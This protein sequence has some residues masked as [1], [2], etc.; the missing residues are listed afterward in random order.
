MA[1][2]ASTTPTATINTYFYHFK[3][4][5]A[6]PTAADFAKAEK[7]VD[8]KSYGDLGGEPNALDATTLSDKVQ[9]TVNGVQKLE[10]IKLT[11][12][13][14]KGDSTKLATLSALGEGEW[15][16][17]AMGASADGTPDG[18]DGIYYWQGGLSYYEN[19]GEVDKVRETTIVVSCATAPT[20]L[21]DAA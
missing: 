6:K 14:T 20:L 10:A 18:H 8:I 11:S 19:G 9:K 1:A 21:P 5:T 4:L 7:V 3:S 13:Y 12:N 16:A 2:A 15:W 17:I